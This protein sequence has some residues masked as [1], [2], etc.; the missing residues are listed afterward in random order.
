SGAISPGDSEQVNVTVSAAT[1]PGGEYNAEV[2]VAS[3]D[4]ASP[5]LFAFADMSVTDAADLDLSAQTLDFGP[6]FVATAD[7]LA[8]LAINAGVLPLAVSQLQV[9]GASFSCDSTALALDPGEST[10]VP[11]VFAPLAGGPHAAT[12]RLISNDPDESDL[13]VQLLG[14][15]LDPPRISV[16]A[17]SVEH[18]LHVGQRITRILQIETRGGSDLTFEV[19]PQLS[20]GI[21]S[22]ARA[23][24]SL[25]P[26][27]AGD[28][29]ATLPPSEWQTVAPALQPRAQ[30]FL[31]TG[32]DGRIF[33][34]AGWGEGSSATPG[35]EIYDPVS[36]TWS[37]GAPLPSNDRGMAAAVDAAGN[38]YAF[39]AVEPNS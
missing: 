14:D 39:S 26:G 8:L 16:A 29:M 23:K 18:V 21:P 27:A 35:L 15:G 37:T 17:D 19:H 5:R 3:N 11:I 31:V 12:L 7:T 30:H 22:P 10:H 28:E 24:P 34:C 38:V 1:L 36:D 32:A 13:V 2:V 20:D 25:R 33:M 4:P 6:V 9:N